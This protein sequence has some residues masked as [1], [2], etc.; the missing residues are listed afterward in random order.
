MDNDPNIIREEAL[1]QLES[2]N[3]LSPTE[4]LKVLLGINP[5]TPLSDFTA[6]KLKKSVSNVLDNAESLIS[7]IANQNNENSTKEILSLFLGVDIPK[8][9]I[10]KPINENLVQQIYKKLLSYNMELGSIN[11]NTQDLIKF[12]S[13]I[14]QDITK[15]TQSVLEQL[16]SSN[17]YIIPQKFIENPDYTIKLNPVQS[18]N[19]LDNLAKL[20][21]Q[22]TGIMNDKNNFANIFAKNYQDIMSSTEKGNSETKGILQKLLELSQEKQKE[23][24]VENPEFYETKPKPYILTDISDDAL[25]KIKELLKASSIK[26]EKRSTEKK[27]TSS[28]KE[29]S[30]GIIG[31][32]AGAIGEGI[33][34]NYLYNKIFGKKGVTGIGKPI[35]RRGGLGR[36]IVDTAKG[37]LGRNVTRFAGRRLLGLTGKIAFLITVMDLF[38]GT[39]L[40]WVDKI[41]G[42]NIKP[43]LDSITEP[44]KPIWDKIATVAESTLAVLTLKDTGVFKGISELFTK[45]AARTALGEV[46]GKVGVRGALAAGGGAL[47]A[48]GAMGLGRGL[49][50][51]TATNYLLNLIPKMK[52]DEDKGFFSNLLPDSVNALRETGID[53]TTGA[54]AG[55][56]QAGPA[57]VVPGALAGAIYSLGKGIWGIGSTLYEGAKSKDEQM[58]IDKEM[59][60][61]WEK[62]YGKDWRNVLENNKKKFEAY[63]KERRDKVKAAAQESA[64]TSDLNKI[65]AQEINGVKILPQP[66]NEDYEFQ[67]VPTPEVKPYVP[68]I[69]ET[70]YP[71]KIQKGQWDNTLEI[72][73]RAT[74]NVFGTKEVDIASMFRSLNIPSS[75]TQVID[76]NKAA[77]SSITEAIINGFDNL[78]L[79]ALAG[80]QIISM[81]GGG[82]SDSI[83]S[84]SRLEMIDY[85]RK[86]Y[87]KDTYNG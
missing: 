18:S 61:M 41:A 64:T 86:Q 14:E 58:A 83:I 77:L 57:G 17:N 76:F 31:T 68:K 9:D 42:T 33:L 20:T 38:G 45:Q 10:L 8:T 27:K 71:G 78:N 30:G 70:N 54:T 53:V 7:K 23:E 15:K 37:G 13:K 11:D 1:K 85:S 26:I 63:S 67:F 72:K 5:E 29:A 12:Q 47:A 34:G 79:G 19:T 32:I 3:T 2:I 25:E 43:A 35:T 6:D 4:K 66:L 73:P 36:P 46:A 49:L 48:G 21:E 59:E 28:E 52:R 75:I 55:L 56:A 22:Q 40:G 65:R 74:Q 84:G 82:S 87:L 24:E 81:D 44:L 69:P 39:I 60:T 62:R 80:D 16:A 50:A 51:G